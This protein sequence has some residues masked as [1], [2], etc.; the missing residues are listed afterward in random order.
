MVGGSGF[1][2]RR[3][4]ASIPA[5][6]ALVVDARGRVGEYRGEWCGRWY[7]RP[8]TGGREWSVAPEGVRP[9]SREQRLQ[10]EVARANAR[11]RGEVL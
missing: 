11:S 4:P 7:L 9:A 2:K 1:G 3:V 5:V 8:V 6:G 10:A